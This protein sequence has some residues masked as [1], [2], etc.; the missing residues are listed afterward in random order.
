MEYRKAEI[1]DIPHLVELRKQQL[2]DEGLMSEN[3]I[4]DE[5][6]KYFTSSLADGSLISWLAINGNEIIA[7]SGICFYRL[8]PSYSNPTGWVAYVTNMFT[9]KEYRKQGIATKLLKLVLEEAKS[10]KYKIVRLHASFDGKP[11]YSRFGFVDSEG[12]M[13]LKI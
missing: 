9:L 6:T 2:L 11:I 8:P 1:N 7:T 13:V 12:Y 3:N 4:D 10:Q 5:L